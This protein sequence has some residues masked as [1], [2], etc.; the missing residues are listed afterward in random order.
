MQAIDA[1]KPYKRPLGQHYQPGR[2]L[3]DRSVSHPLP[4]TEAR[5]ARM[6]FAAQTRPSMG[7][8]LPK[9]RHFGKKEVMLTLFVVIILIGGILVLHQ[10][11]GQLLVLLYGVVA[12]LKR[13]PAR[14]TFIC[15]LVSLLL[16][17][18]SLAIFGGFNVISSAFANYAFL[19]LMIGITSVAIELRRE[20][21]Y[22]HGRLK[23]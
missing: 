12:V 19:L 5:A 6:Q 1:V 21:K 17:P 11:A 2:K 7:L 15:A 22:L 3:V 20:P 8:R 16:V 4:A 9:R 10:S 23:P 14:V 18:V 13:I